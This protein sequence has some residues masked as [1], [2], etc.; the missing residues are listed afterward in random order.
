MSRFA[1]EALG[2]ILVVSGMV[3]L[4]VLFGVEGPGD[5]FVLQFA[6]LWMAARGSTALV[7]RLRGRGPS[8]T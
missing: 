6:A 7:R 1:R 2:L 3:Y 5:L 8:V 4:P